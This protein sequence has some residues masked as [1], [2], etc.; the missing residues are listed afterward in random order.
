MKKN[1]LL[2]LSGGLDSCSAL[3]IYK[4]SIA[5][6][7]SFNYGANHNAQEIKMAKLNCERLNIPHKVIDLTAVFKGMGSALLGNG[8]IPEG[9]YESETMKSTVVP[10]RNGIFLS[11]LAGIADDAGLGKV[12][13]ASH[14]GD[15]AVY[16]DCRP[17]FNQAMNQAIMLGTDRLIQLITP[18]ADIGKPEL[19]Q[20]GIAAGMVP[21]QTYSC[22][23][24]GAIQCGV[25]STCRERDWALGL[26][27]EP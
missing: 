17:E 7:V 3:H 24:G 14:S 16:A 12:M 8:P 22:Y 25:C 19:A 26:R 5:L 21:E 6:A 9:H 18:F 23:K 4:D 20:L 13:I 11:V 15:N 2:S 27:D 10:F 1:T